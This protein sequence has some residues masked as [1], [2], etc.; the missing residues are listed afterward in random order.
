MNEGK[1]CQFGTPREIVQHPE[2]PFVETLIRSAREQE[3]LWEE[4]L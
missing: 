3:R 4:L 1:V 2:D